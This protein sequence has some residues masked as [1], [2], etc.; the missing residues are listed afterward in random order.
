M[1][2]D[3][4]KF[5]GSLNPILAGPFINLTQI[6][7]RDQRNTVLDITDQQI[8]TSLPKKSFHNHDLWPSSS[9]VT[10]TQFKHDLSKFDTSLWNTPLDKIPPTDLHLQPLWNPAGITW[11]NSP[12]RLHN[13]CIST[14]L[15]S[16]SFAIDLFILKTSRINFWKS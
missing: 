14:S 9:K 1:T 15:N 4:C 8:C 7:Y 6:Y 3:P 5:N 2:L 16:G 11:D 12:L 10:S 13:M